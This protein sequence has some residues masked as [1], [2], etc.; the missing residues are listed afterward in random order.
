[1]GREI[2]GMVET[3]VRL[4][5]WEIY[6]KINAWEN[7]E[8]RF[9]FGTIDWEEQKPGFGSNRFDFFFFSNLILFLVI[10]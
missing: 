3:R 8:I 1:M 10:V 4:G 6:Y 7:W 2:N 5:N 9:G